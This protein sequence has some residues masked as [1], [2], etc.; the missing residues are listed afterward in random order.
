MKLSSV[1]LFAVAAALAPA[2]AHASTT[3]E[4]TAAVRFM[5]GSTILFTGR[6]PAR[7]GL[8]G[9]SGAHS[10][11][12]IE[13]PGRMPVSVSLSSTPDGLDTVT[14]GDGVP[15][16]ATVAWHRGRLIRVD[17][18]NGRAVIFSSPGKGES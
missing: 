13:C 11:Y 3:A 6:C 16:A 17:F 18:G 5:A 15:E 8:D 12:D 2:Y 7:F 4:Y 9:A 10:F 14:L 1:R